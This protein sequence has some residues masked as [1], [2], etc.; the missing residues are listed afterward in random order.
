MSSNFN[1]INEN[2]EKIIELSQLD[3]DNWA[4]TI[5][6][7]AVKLSSN[8]FV[9]TDGKQLQN[10]LNEIDAEWAGWDGVKKWCSVEK[11]FCLD[12]ENDKKGHIKCSVLLRG[13]EEFD[14]EFNMKCDLLA[15]DFSEFCKKYNE[16]IN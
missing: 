2:N 1:F 10:I 3:V 16:F 8:V 15:A 12:F 4:V 13:S 14:W 11:D 9:Y 6:C 7:G 5:S